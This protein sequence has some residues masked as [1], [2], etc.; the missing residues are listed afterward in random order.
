MSVDRGPWTV[1]RSLAFFL[2]PFSFFLFL[3]ACSPKNEET[4]LKEDLQRYLEEAEKWAPVE[5]RINGPIDAVQ[6]SQFVNEQFVLST[7]R[8]IV[9]IAQDYVRELEGYQPETLTLQDV[10]RQ[11]IEAWRSHH[12]ACATIV[13]AMEKQDY[14]LL[15]KGTEGLREARMSLRDVLAGLSQLLVQS[16]LRS[17]ETEVAEGQRA[18]GKD[19]RTGRG[20]ALGHKFEK[21]C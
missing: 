6:R 12:L 7:L 20:E 3:V 5:A 15:A 17:P 9:S 19:D 4:A 11:Y 1:S 13:E 8:P 14:I 21:A 16:G 10:H 18:K 2:F